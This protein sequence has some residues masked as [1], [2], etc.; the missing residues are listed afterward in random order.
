MQD[1]QKIIEVIQQTCKEKN[2]SPNRA[3]IESGVGQSLIANMLKGQIPAVN[4]ISDL[5]DY[6]DVS[7]DYLLG[8]TDNPEVNK[9]KE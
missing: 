8:R 2:I 7:I 3:F 6:L 4:K 9:I 5:A 1:L